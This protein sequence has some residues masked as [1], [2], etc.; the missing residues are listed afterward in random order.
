METKMNK[1]TR[2]TTIILIFFTAVLFLQSGCA[3]NPVTGKKEIMLISES[4]EINMGKEIDRGL[5]MEYGIYDDPQLNDYVAEVGQEMVPYCHRPHL[6][7]HFAILDTQVENAFAAPGGYIYVTRGLMAM[8]N[9]EA[10]LATVLGHELGHVNARHSA[11]QMTRAILFELGIALASE[12]SKD[13]RKIAPI[14]MIATQLLFLKYSRD[15]EYQADAL[16]IEYSLKTG[17]SAYEMVN[18]FTSLQRLTESQGGPG[19]PNF[20]STHPLTPKRIA[21]VKELL[22]VEENSRPGGLGQL[23]VEHNSHINRLNG[24]IYGMNPRQGYIQGSMFYHPEMR[25]YF[26][27]PSGWKV[28]N[29]PLQVTMASADGKAVILLK[30][31]NTTEGL[32]GY[33]QKMMKELTNPTVIQ[34]GYRYVNGLNAFHTLASMVNQEDSGEGQSNAPLNVQISC[35]RKEGIIFTFFSAAMQSD[36]P[37][38]QYAINNTIN[39]FRNLTDSRYLQRRPSRLSIRRVNG[40]Q[41]L[42]SFLNMLGIPQQSWNQIAIIN[43]MDLNQQL[44][45]NQLVKIVN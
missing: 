15:N 23:K 24:L 8:L 12:L 19:L 21:R 6:Q 4:M 32:D 42:S 13:F 28:D 40:A 1:Y 22:Q 45:A 17:Y 35:I 18:F 3:V 26:M 31:E 11:Q 7:Y 9:S 41:T 25:F 10:E 5:R 29:T 43:G 14:S 36:F 44:A 16:G 39:S 34:Q 30:A 2:I 27:I 20:L 38:Y 33:T 37:S